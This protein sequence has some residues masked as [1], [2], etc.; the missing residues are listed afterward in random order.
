MKMHADSVKKEG[1]NID[2]NKK[3]KGTFIL[4]AVQESR[5]IRGP[6]QRLVFAITGCIVGA[7]VGVLR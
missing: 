1:R 7:V 2:H 3:I 5:D 4:S 6:D